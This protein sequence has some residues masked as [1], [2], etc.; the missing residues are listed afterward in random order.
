MD[1]KLFQHYF[2]HNL[3]SEDRAKL[4]T[5]RH[6][7]PSAALFLE[8]IDKCKKVTPPP[9]TAHTLS[10][11]D[12]EIELLVM[13]LFADTIHKKD[14]HAFIHGLNDPHFFNKVMNILRV[15]ATPD[16]YTADDMP[17]IRI[18]TTDE[19][20]KRLKST[21]AESTFVVFINKVLEKL[22]QL[23]GKWIA[24]PATVVAAIALAILIPYQLQSP[25]EFYIKYFDNS[26]KAV[27]IQKTSF[28]VLKGVRS[29]SEADSLGPNDSL[30][31][32]YREAFGDYLVEDYKKALKKFNDLEADVVALPESEYN[33]Y[34]KSEFNFYSGL[35]RL[36]LAGNRGWRKKNL[37]K[38]IDY[39]SS[40]LE[41]AQAYGF[42][43]QTEVPFFLA[44]AYK[45]KGDDREA[46]RILAE[47][48]IHDKYKA[49]SEQLR[50]NK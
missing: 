39:L 12:D 6:E 42:N 13:R 46:Q 21:R 44:M 18:Q 35:C 30:I 19:I 43:H 45:M 3:S 26:D 15:A 7:E 17:D 8:L 23:H 4:D 1:Y 2:R 41:T 10:Y 48:P 29:F 11:S 9:Q 31:T 27:Q 5:L 40:S 47:Y 25:N 50:S 33:A 38:S 32:R 16:I 36:N 22:G 20:F 28:N 49:D 37:Q 24:V 34:I 14:A